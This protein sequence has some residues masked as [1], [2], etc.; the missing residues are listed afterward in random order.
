MNGAEFMDLYQKSGV[1]LKEPDEVNLHHGCPNRF[2]CW[3][4]S[5]NIDKF[6]ASWNRIQKPY[7]GL[8]Y[9]GEL[10]VV[11][12]NLNTY[13][14]WG[15]LDGLFWGENDSKGVIEYIR[16]GKKR[17]DFNSAHYF[18]TIL[19]HRI[20]V[21]SSILIDHLSFKD[22]STLSSGEIRTLHNDKDNLSNVLKKIAYTNAI[23]CSPNWHLSTPTGGMKEICPSFFLVS[24]IK[25]L[26]PRSILLLNKI[27]FD[28]LTQRY[29]LESTGINEGMANYS[30]LSVDGHQCD[31]FRILHP[32][33]RKGRSFRAGNSL[34]NTQDLY[35]LK[36]KIS[37]W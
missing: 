12:L 13:G 10:L 37:Q 3:E 23:K 36:Q 29:A 26:K 1:F 25:I 14:G 15:C 11:G 24:E 20:A 33:A 30:R 35:S 34:A 31:L 21:Y 22:Q 9:S 8:E 17:I 16:Q 7:I 6:G 28:L 5:E 2:V 19:F 27:T 4:G 18:G 32:T